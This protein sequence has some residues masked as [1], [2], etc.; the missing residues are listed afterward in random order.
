M[1]CSHNQLTQHSGSKAHLR[2]HPK[3]ISGHPLKPRTLR[4]LLISIAL[5][6][7]L[8]S[9]CLVTLSGRESASDQIFYHARENLGRLSAH[10]IEQ[11]HGYLR[12]ASIALQFGTKLINDGTLDATS[13]ADLQLHIVAKLHAHESIE[14]MYL[15]RDDGSFVFVARDGDG[16]LV[17]LSP[18]VSAQRQITRIRYNAKGHAVRSWVEDDDGYDPRTRPWFKKAR[19]LDSLAWT[20]AYVFFTSQQP[21]ISAGMHANLPDGNSAG[22]LGVDI[23]I[24]DLSQLVASLPA[25]QGGSAIIVDQNGAVLADSDNVRSDSSNTSTSRQQLVTVDQLSDRS[26]SALHTHLIDSSGTGSDT[27]QMTPLKISNQRHL[28]FYR[29]FPLENSDINWQLLMTVPSSAVVGNMEQLF[30]DKLIK[31]IAALILP[32]LIT[33]PLITWLTK[34]IYRYHQRATVDSMTGALS[35][36]EFRER[37]GHM[38]E[39]RQIERRGEI[40][41]LVVMDLDG[42]KEVNDQF[43]HDT[44]DAALA[45]VSRRWQSR[46]RKDDLLGRMG[47]DEFMVALRLSDAAALTGALESFVSCFVESLRCAGVAEPIKTSKALIQVGATAGVTNYLKG[48]GIDAL[49]SRAD[50]ALITGKTMEKNRCHFALK[51]LNLERGEST[52]SSRLLRRSA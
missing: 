7:Q 43:G 5:T 45:E 34:P 41:V 50:N 24:Q 42:F 19:D 20:D 36:D 44:G 11:A 1:K 31:L 29:P 17:K 37:L 48:E 25:A 49:I 26:L 35:R 10:V 13:D 23:N 46:L 21:G 22:V 2:D 9:V 33:V 3:T 28:G 27:M 16:F 51:R 40:L 39:Q 12:Q 32:A 38:I 14:A 4:I 47:G 15:G 6:V 30:N 52:N 18:P 8:V